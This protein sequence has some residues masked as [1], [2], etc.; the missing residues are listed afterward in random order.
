MLGQRSIQP[1]SLLIGRVVAALAASMAG[2]KDLTPAAW[3]GVSERLDPW[4]TP[5]HIRHRLMLRI[6]TC[7]VVLLRHNEGSQ[8]PVG[9]GQC[10]EV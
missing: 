1:S 7:A 2:V 8:I 3:G 10:F 4:T 9:G 6:F 5:P